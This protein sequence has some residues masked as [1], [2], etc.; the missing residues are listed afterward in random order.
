[1]KIILYSTGCPMCKVLKSKLNIAGVVYEEI[2]DQETMIQKGFK[3]A[4][5]LEV[6]GK[7]LN[8]NEAIGWVKNY[9]H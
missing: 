3:S 1:M 8:F 6:E 7:A 2:N 4:P 9:E 5:I